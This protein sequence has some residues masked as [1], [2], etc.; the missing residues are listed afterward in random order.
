MNFITQL[1]A[2][3]QLTS[4]NNKRKV[5][6]KEY[7]IFCKEFVF[8]KL[9]GKSFGETFCDKFNFN[10]MFLKNLSDDIAKDQIET[11]GYI[12]K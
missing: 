4:N 5:S 3:E 8:D 11:L 10:G 1:A 6:K 12:E 7:E 9:K 2:L